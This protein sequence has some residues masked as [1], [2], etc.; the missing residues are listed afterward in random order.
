MIS[1]DYSCLFFSSEGFLNKWTPH[2]FPLFPH[3]CHFV[4]CGAF[5]SSARLLH[6]FATVPIWWGHHST[7]VCFFFFFHSHLFLFVRVHCVRLSPRVY[8]CSFPP[9][10]SLRLSSVITALDSSSDGK[11][12]SIPL[13]P[14]LPPAK[15][16]SF[17]CSHQANYVL[18][19]IETCLLNAF[20]PHLL[21]SSPRC[22]SP[23]FSSA[24]PVF[25]LFSHPCELLA[26]CVPPLPIFSLFCCLRSHF[27]VFGD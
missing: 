5:F 13:S 7:R 21:T 15:S 27:N 10:L 26:T 2:N 8:L 19:T 9:P 6:L 22:P 14:S 18:V 20:P 24:Q 4:L 16:P 17:S 11:C 23:S 3:L 1:Q 12:F 25:T